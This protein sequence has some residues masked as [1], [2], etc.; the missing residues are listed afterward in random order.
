M[1][2][3]ISCIVLLLVYYFW[4]PKIGAEYIGLNGAIVK[5]ESYTINTIIVCYKS[6]NDYSN[7][8][9]LSRFHFKTN[10]VRWKS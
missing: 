8:I 6:G 4:P 9:N 10:F 3:I 5:I 1:W 2:I 7:P